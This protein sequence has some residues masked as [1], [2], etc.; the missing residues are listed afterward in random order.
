MVFGILMGLM[1][2]VPWEVLELGYGR[3]DWSFVITEGIWHMV[4]EGIGGIA[5]AHVYGRAITA[6]A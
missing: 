3:G 4:E 5:M 6:A 1:A 2:R